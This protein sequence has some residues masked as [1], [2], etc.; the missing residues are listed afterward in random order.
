MHSFDLNIGE[1]SKIEGKA[2]LT[3]K[4]ENGEVKEC[5][6]K[7][8][9]FKRFYTQA[10]RGKDI[11]ALPQLTSRICGTCSNA[12]LLCA[13]KAVEDAQKI[14][15]TPQT[16]ALRKL[17]NF[18][19]IIRDHALHLY[20]FVMPDLLGVDNIL[21][22]DEN[23]PREHQILDDAFAIKAAGNNLSKVIGG[24]SV[25]APFPMVGGFSKIPD[26]KSFTELIKELENIRS[27]V[28][29]L[30]KIFQ[31][32]GSILER[33]TDFVALIDEEYSFLKGC[34]IKNDDVTIACQNYGAYLDKI[35][36][37]Y[38][39]AIGY[40][41][42]G[43]IHM[44]GALARLNLAK[45]KL[46]RRTKEEIKEVLKR[47]PSKNIFYNNLAQAIE[48]LHAIDSSIEILSQLS[49]KEE[50]L[51]PIVR[52]EGI[53]VGVIEAPRG[54]LYYKLAINKE[55]KVINGDI[56][57]PTGQNQIG[58]ERS[59]YEYV[60]ANVDKK[61][62]ELINEIEKIIRAYDPCM[63]CASHFLRVKWL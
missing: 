52:K 49:I 19:L 31:D 10:I 15:P 25:H 3:I 50:K 53:G 21:E 43:R 45:E 39:H 58:I 35:V 12:H 9:E 57:V 28:L 33:N 62:E 44:I 47:F 8:D 27:A 4:V 63:S 60:K 54:T 7:I 32:D 24:R 36:L 51:V 29:R 1:L 30:I 34:I 48:I 38:S 11:L 37:P 18:G 46:N 16:E 55:G 17:L 14:Q 61:R 5:R 6:F 23:D 2:S 20:I 13:I 26:E 42:M 59:I 40:K 41:F 56:V 22:L